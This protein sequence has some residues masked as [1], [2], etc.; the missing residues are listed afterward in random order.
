MSHFKVLVIGTNVEDQLEKFD[1]C[2]EMPQY[3][4]YTKEDLIQ[5]FKNGLES[6]KNGI[7]AEYLKD[8][9]KYAEENNAQEAHLNYLSTEFPQR[10]SW[11]DEQIYA[12]QI[13]D[14]E[15]AEI[16]PEGGV[17]STYNPNSKW[18][19]YVEGGRYKNSLLLKN[20]KHVDSAIKSQID[21]AKMRELSIKQRR[22]NYQECMKKIEAG[23]TFAAYL[24]SVECKDGIFETEEEYVGD[25]SFSCFAVVKDGKWYERG[26]MGWWAIVS[27]ENKDWDKELAKLIAES[28]ENEKFTI[29]DCHI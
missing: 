8:R 17:Y 27:N 7:Y 20:G 28:P 26:E 2:L 19:W 11:S 12:H 5:N 18:D 15:E 21:W 3:V 14:Y 13:A 4:R 23:E 10:L 6:Y 24:Y 25:G 29:V 9:I 1:E 22:E 16:T